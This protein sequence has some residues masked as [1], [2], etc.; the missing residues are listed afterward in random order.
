M[1]TT[2]KKEPSTAERIGQRSGRLADRT[3]CGDYIVVDRYE[4]QGLVEDAVREGLRSA[5]GDD[6]LHEDLWT[7]TEAAQHLGVSRQLVLQFARDAG[8]PH[9]RFGALTPTAVGAVARARAREA[10]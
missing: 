2:P 8:L 5:L 10:G 9:R 6:V 3:A 1:A 4:L 7:P